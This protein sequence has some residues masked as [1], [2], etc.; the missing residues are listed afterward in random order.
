MPVIELLGHCLDG[1]FEIMVKITLGFFRKL[2]KVRS[3][4]AKTRKKGLN[5]CTCL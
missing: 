5:I 3:F 4:K 1:K 2:N